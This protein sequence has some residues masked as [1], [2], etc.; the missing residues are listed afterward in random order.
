MIIITDY[1]PLAR[2]HT[3]AFV[4]IRTLVK[5]EHLFKAPLIVY[6]YYIAIFFGVRDI[7]LGNSQPCLCASAL[8]GRWDV[9]TRVRKAETHRHGK[10]PELT[11]WHIPDAESV[12]NK[13]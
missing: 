5:K 4:T 10:V 3:K 1:Q 9:N 2:R 7:T 12:M 13:L 8:Y 11:P 6:K